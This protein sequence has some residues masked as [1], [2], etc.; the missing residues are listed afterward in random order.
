[1][2]REQLP[3][4]PRRAL[5]TALTSIFV[6]GLGFAA[7]ATQ[8][9]GQVAQEGGRDIKTIATPPPKYPGYAFEHNLEGLVVM[10]VDVAADGS[11]TGAIVE[12]AEP[13]GVFEEAAMAAVKNWKFT[14]AMK[15]GKAIAGQVRVP[16]EFALDPKEGEESKPMKVDPGHDPD[17]A[18]YDWIKLGA[19]MVVSEAECDVVKRD[20]EEDTTYCGKL[21][22]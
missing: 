22:R 1:M 12:R 8:P 20:I 19:S 4:T 16:I 13:K 2:L 10:R 21:R 7:W 6:F 11:V 18:A 5:G 14:P 17:P 15:D 9:Q 3:S